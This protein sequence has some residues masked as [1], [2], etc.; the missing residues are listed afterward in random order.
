MGPHAA[1]IMTVMRAMI[2]AAGLP[3]IFA[4]A[5]EKESN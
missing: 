2:N 3:V 5:D 1:Q 4:T